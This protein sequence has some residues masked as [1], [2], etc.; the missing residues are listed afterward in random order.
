MNKDFISYNE[1]IDLEKLGFCFNHGYMYYD[2]SK[3]VENG[4]TY[5]PLYQQAFD[6]LLKEY[7]LYGLVLPTVTIDWT[8][9]TMTVVD[10]PIEK[11]FPYEHIPAYDYSNH[12]EARFECLKR[13]IELAKMEK[14]SNFYEVY[15]A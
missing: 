6:F 2:Q 9:K 8:F 5:V 1:F 14:E 10:R 13:L 12:D 4:Y 15:K 11:V 3:S 7:Y